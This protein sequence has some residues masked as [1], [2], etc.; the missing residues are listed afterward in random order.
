VF[1]TARQIYRQSQKPQDS[2]F[3]RRIA[4]PPAAVVVA[5]LADTPITPNQVTFMSLALMGVAA[6]VLVGVPSWAG[7]WLGV[8]LVEASY[9]L[10]CADG[11]LARYT[12]RTS[13]VGGLLDFLMDELKAFLLV[14]ALAIRW[15][16][17]EG[18][19][20]LALYVGILSLVVVGSAIALTKFVRTPEYAEASG[21]PLRKHGESAGS[22]DGGALW[23]IIAAF[24]LISQY[25]ASLPIF[26]LF[27]RMD[28]FLFVY[29]G[30][31]ALY[32][33]ATALSI[34]RALGR[35]TRR[36]TPGEGT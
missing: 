17:W 31:H 26:A 21:T 28:I 15:H 12:G 8:L 34:V 16:L 14:A 30:L 10:D 35:P 18:G 29:G 32:L 24:R 9:V 11:Q 25:P 33:G 22:R 5:K 27:G 6:L 4:R 13:P 1:E 19:G 3:N 20:L 23:P 7:L 2:W 36:S